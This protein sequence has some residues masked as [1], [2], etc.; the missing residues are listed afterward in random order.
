[1][2]LHAYRKQNIGEHIS[3][4]GHFCLC[5]CILHITRHSTLIHTSAEIAAIAL[6]VENDDCKHRIRWY[7]SRDMKFGLIP[8]KCMESVQAGSWIK[9]VLKMK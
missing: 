8:Q 7:T 2:A 6:Q 4:V 3:Q 9:I 1:M 5:V